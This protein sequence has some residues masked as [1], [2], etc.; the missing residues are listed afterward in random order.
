MM[1]MMMMMMMMRE[2]RSVPDSCK[3]G[4]FPSAE[5]VGIG[6]SSFGPLG[7]TVLTEM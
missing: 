2:K 4:R 3:L 7:R 1:M 6:V 5:R